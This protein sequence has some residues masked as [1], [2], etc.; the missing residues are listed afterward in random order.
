M[1]CGDCNPVRGGSLVARRLGEGG[2][3]LGR[4]SS[5]RGQG[6]GREGDY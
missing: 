5:M 4:R 1:W 6:L 3:L 2:S